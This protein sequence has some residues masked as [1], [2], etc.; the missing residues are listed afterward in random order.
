MKFKSSS[1]DP[2]QGN[3]FLQKIFGHNAMR[4]NKE[5]KCCFACQDP[6]KP[7]PTR[8]LYPNRK[9]YPFMKHILSV[10]HFSLLLGCALAVG[11][12]TID[13]LGRHVDKMRIS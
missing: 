7:I 8:K 5:F 6:R 1:V 2:V 11:E 4:R 9:L 3:D 10:F 13:F 12:Q